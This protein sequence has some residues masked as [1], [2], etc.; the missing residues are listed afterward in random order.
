MAELVLLE[1]TGNHVLREKKPESMLR[2][3]ILL[4]YVG[5]PCYL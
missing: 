4:D 3:K 1:D 2:L 5:I